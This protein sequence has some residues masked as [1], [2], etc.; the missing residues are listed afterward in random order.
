M[1]T[2]SQRADLARLIDPACIALVGA[3][4]RPHSIGGRTL[5]NLIDHST[6]RGEL[7]LVNPTKTE[8]RGRRCWPSIAAL[9]QTPDVAIIAV[10]AAGVLAVAEEC[11]ARGVPYLV[12]LT[13]GFGEAGAEGK[14][15]QQRLKEI[16]DAAGMRIYGPNCPGLCNINARLGMTFSPS[17]PHDLLPGP[18]GLATQGGGLGRNVMQAMER[19]VGIGLWASTGNEVDLQVADFIHYMATAPDIKV[20]ITLLEG[21]KDGPR[22][23]AALQCAADNGKPVIALKVGKSE[24]GQ[25][26][27]QSHTASLTG[28]AEVNSAVFRQYGVI[29]VDDIDELVD[30]AWL[31]A[32]A[33]P[34]AQ[35]AIG[36]YCSSGG[37]AALTADA[38]GTSGLKLAEFAPHTRELLRSRLP[39]YAAIDNPVDTT[40]AILADAD[41][42]EQTLGA[43]TTDPNVGC[44][45][46]PIALEYGATTVSLAHTI[47]AAQQQ[48][49]STP[50]IPIWMS[51]RLGEG[52]RLLVEGGFAPPRSVGKALKAVQRWT[53]WGRWRRAGGLG[54]P[55]RP[56]PAPS[57]VPATGTVRNLS[58]LEAKQLLAQSGIALLPAA[59][60]PTREEARRIADE[61][62][63]PVVAKIASPDVVHKSDIGGV[64]VG[65][66]SGAEVEQ[67]W[68]AIM[69]SV[70]QH[71]PMA[72]IDGLL[73]EKMAPRGG[74]ELMVGVTRDP[75]FGHVMTFGLGGIY[76]ELLRDVTRRL[77]PL[78]PADASAMVR[79]MRCYPLLQGARG[80]PPADVAALER[81]LLAV[82]DFVM[83]HAGR[84]EEMDLNPVWVGSEGEG[85]LPLDAVIVML[86]GA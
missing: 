64:K 62:G 47:R 28:S 43:V 37:T 70:R 33:I 76:V 35:E 65:L 39:D 31:F 15:A 8:L 42:I 84:L 85:A 12:I 40:A 78:R 57:S 79:E 69:A 49:S 51:D 52:Y 48:Q 56:L 60:A 16:A 21:I 72:A 45:L 14:R 36:I 53:A 22:L 18:I 68:D 17:F 29:E 83:A 4:D 30:T 26:A 34:P 44:V 25:R 2:S 7:Y 23:L 75:V 59:V 20:I 11:A 9:P 32:R 86:D 50:I 74:F 71:K 41:L 6:L 55:R 5:T 61:M 13:S 24:Y 46:A 81:L 80:K 3:S 38:V 82:S 58:E 19:G 77:L 54:A 66:A 1:T 63:Y 10:P 67:A 73:I 27:A